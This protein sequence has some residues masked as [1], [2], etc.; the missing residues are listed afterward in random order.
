MFDLRYQLRLNDVYDLTAT[1]VLYYEQVQQHISL[2]DHMLVGEIPIRY[3]QVTNRLY[4]DMD[5]DS[6]NAGEYILIECFRKLDPT[7]YTD[8]YN[9][10]WLKRYATA[11]VKYQW[12]SNLSKFGGMQLPGGVELNGNEIMTQAQ[13]EIRRLEEESRLNY[14]LPPID[15]IG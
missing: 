10:M 11:L 7:T 4:L 13:E 2:L 6:I 14:E 8:I 9:D 3:K 15:M 1:N 5:K 12:G